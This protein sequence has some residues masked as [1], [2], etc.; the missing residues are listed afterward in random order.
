VPLL[1]AGLAQHDLRHRPASRAFTPGP[2]KADGE[3]LLA[4][5]CRQMQRDHATGFGLRFRPLAQGRA[6][7]GFHVESRGITKL[8]LKIPRA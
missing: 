1:L 8:K 6:A 2:D 7:D 4:W 3:F 5:S